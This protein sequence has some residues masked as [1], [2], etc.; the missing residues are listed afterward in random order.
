MAAR[1]QSAST[2]APDAPAEAD[3]EQTGA[4][5]APA[6]PAPQEAP[7]KPA[8]QEAKRGGKLK[9]YRTLTAIGKLRRNE[10]FEA[11]PDDPRVKSGWVRE[12]GTDGVP[13]DVADAL[14]G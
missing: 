6:D 10:E 13:A 3:G 8:P 12:V 2:D 5:E 9:R 7:A 1:K 14:G 4:Q 11:S